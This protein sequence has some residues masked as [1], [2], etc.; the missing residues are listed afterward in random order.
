M[1]LS[2]WVHKETI[3]DSGVFSDGAMVLIERLETTCKFWIQMRAKTMKN[4][5][6]CIT[7]QK[8]ECHDDGGVYHF[9]DHKIL[10]WNGFQFPITILIDK[11]KVIV[12]FLC[13]RLPPPHNTKQ[14]PKGNERWPNWQA[15]DC[16]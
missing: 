2:C 8:L 4:L 6:Q 14:K 12:I 5:F 13:N 1:V 9:D 11:K 7:I 15:R 3:D 16:K 10:Y